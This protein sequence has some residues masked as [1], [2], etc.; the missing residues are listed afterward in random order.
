MRP[1]TEQMITE[2]VSKTEDDILNLMSVK[3]DKVHVRLKKLETL[4]HKAIKDIAEIRATL[5]DSI[6]TGDDPGSSSE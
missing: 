2:A 3:F 5:N 1:A 6:S 4:L